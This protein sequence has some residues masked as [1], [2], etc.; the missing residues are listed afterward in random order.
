MEKAVENKSD[1]IEIPIGKVLN[2]LRDNPW[3]V[4]TFVLAI[5]LIVIFIF[6]RTGSVVS[7]EAVAAKVLAF[8]DSNP[9]I[10]G[11]ASLVSVQRNGQLYKIT[12]NFQ[13][14]ETPVYTTLDGMFLISSVT[15]LSD[16]PESSVGGNAVY[17]DTS[18]SVDDDAVLGR[19]DA[20]VTIIEFSDY[21]CPFCRKF[22]TE[23][24][25]LLKSDYIDTGKVK[26]V[27][28]DYPLPIHPLAQKSAEAAECV[29]EQG[30]DSAYYQFH[31]KIYGE[32]NI[33]DG[34]TLNG[35]VTTTVQY[36]VDDL[37]KWA[38][39]IDYDINSCLNSGKYENEVQKDLADGGSL[40]TPTF[41]I[42]GIKVEGAQ[43]YSVFKK[44]IDS[45]LEN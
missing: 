13:G 38:R 7:E 1:V 30:G 31:D 35:P 29:R 6:G 39:D 36:T 37:K 24:F 45:E 21:Q 2:K 18:V 26:L 40:G 32:E 34:G 8:I 22:W 10:A 27:Y 42:N 44:I 5:F 3:I 43:P 33:L 9:E 16:L 14:Q 25:P 23:T 19:T 28:R 15:E 17:R 11:Q 41:Y 12:L 4:S 20:P